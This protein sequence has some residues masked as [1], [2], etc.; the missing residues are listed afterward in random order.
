MVEAVMVG[1]GETTDVG[2]VSDTR[3]V[4]VS[5]GGGGDARGGSSSGSLIEEAEVDI[6]YFMK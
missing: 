5:G 3:T 4:G 6:I 2:V 1:G